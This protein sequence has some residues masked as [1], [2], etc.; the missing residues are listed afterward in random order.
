MKKT[1]AILMILLSVS[2]SCRQNKK[3]HTGNQ[4]KKKEVNIKQTSKKGN[5]CK[6]VHFGYENNEEGPENWKNLCEEFSA[7]GGQ[8]QSPINIETNNYK[9][10]DKLQAINFQYN[11]SNVDII[12]NG[13]TVQFNVTGDNK[14]KFNN[15]NYKLLQFHFHSLSEHTIDGKHYPAEI[16][17]VHKNND[18]DYAVISVLIKEGKENE[19]LKKYLDKFPSKNGNF[20]TDEKLDLNKLLPKEKNYYYY[21]GSLTT[22]PCSE[23]VSWY[24]MKSPIEASKEQIQKLSQI[25]HNNYRPVQNL[26][27]RKVYA[28]DN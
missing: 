21:K 10:S 7:C 25:L 13:H 22:P 19:L 17:F 18:K 14:I 4:E 9:K 3:S 12:N 28:F 6:N 24:L 23:V 27:G 1:I 2:I 8:A 5:D 20:K 15:K 26:N 11:T 16:H